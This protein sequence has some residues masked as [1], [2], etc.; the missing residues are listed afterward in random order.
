MFVILLELIVNNSE[1]NP[2]LLKHRYR[3]SV[4]VIA[5]LTHD[6]FMPVELSSWHM[7]DMASSC[8]TTWHLSRIQAGGLYDK[9]FCS[10]CSVHAVLGNFA[11]VEDFAHVVPCVIAMQQTWGL[12]TSVMVIRVLS[13]TIT[14]P[15]LPRSLDARQRR[16]HTYLKVPIPVWAR[17]ARIN[18]HLYTSNSQHNSRYELINSICRQ[19]ATSRECEFPYLPYGAHPFQPTRQCRVTVYA[20]GPPEQTYRH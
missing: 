17:V 9:R 5:F 2:S 14:Q 19:V 6:S 16:L 13:L 1:L 8:R 20:L 7:F 15:L 3:V 10:A 12:T 18:S 11:V 4:C